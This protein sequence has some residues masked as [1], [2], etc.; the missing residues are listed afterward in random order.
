MLP[1]NSFIA[2]FLAIDSQ[3]IIIALNNLKQ[4]ECGNTVE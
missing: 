2:I 3:E 1:F 4:T